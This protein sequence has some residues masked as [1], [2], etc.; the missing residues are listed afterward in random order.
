MADTGYDLNV[1]K[2]R[3]EGAIAAFKHELSGLR[4][5]R[6]SVSLLEPVM[7]QAYGQSMPIN[8]VGT[9]NGSGAAHGRH[10]G[11][12]QVDGRRGR[13]GDPRVGPRPQPDH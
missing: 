6:A 8:Q 13:A 12:G 4:T 1:L 11:L 7:V 9:I 10:P 5:G 3:M 2:K